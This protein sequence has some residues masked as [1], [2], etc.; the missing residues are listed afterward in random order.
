M[1]SG[2]ASS[3][4]KLPPTRGSGNEA[5]FNI[6]LYLYQRVTVGFRALK[7]KPVYGLLYSLP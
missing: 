4:D 6:Q 7:T 1:R 5:T 2:S 3:G